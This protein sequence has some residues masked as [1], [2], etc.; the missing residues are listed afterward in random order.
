M[1]R[2]PG[3]Q[4][5]SHKNCLSLKTNVRKYII[6]TIMNYRETIYGRCSGMPS[7]SCDVKNQTGTDEIQR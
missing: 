4:T 7:I 5:G 6:C 3:K 1:G 2:S